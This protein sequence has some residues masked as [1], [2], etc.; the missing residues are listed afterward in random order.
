MD[1]VSTFILQTRTLLS[2]SEVLLI[3]MLGQQ[4]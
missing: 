2:E 4:A 3:N 1:S